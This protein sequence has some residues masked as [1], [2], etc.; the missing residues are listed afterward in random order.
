M[1]P[2]SAESRVQ[3]EA[4]EQRHRA[5]SFYPDVLIDELKARDYVVLAKQEHA[6]LID[7]AQAIVERTDVLIDHAEAI[8]DRTDIPR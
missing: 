7:R 4:D 1:S 8:L 6:K 2:Q 5:Q 3:D